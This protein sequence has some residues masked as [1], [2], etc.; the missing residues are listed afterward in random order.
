MFIIYKSIVQLI[1]FNYLTATFY[2]C[3]SENSIFLEL[4]SQLFF[5]LV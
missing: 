2:D 3:V 5:L 4:H 1:L